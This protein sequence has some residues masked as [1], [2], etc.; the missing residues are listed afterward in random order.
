M[1]VEVG[2]SEV[3]VGS[4]DVEVGSSDVEIG[5]SE[6]DVGSS[7]VEIG[8]VLVE[9]GASEVEV[10]SSC[11]DVGSTEVGVGSSVVELGSS[12]LGKEEVV[13]EELELSDVW[14]LGEGL[15]LVQ[16]ARASEK[17]EKRVTRNLVRFMVILS[18]VYAGKG[19]PYLVRGRAGCLPPQNVLSFKGYEE[20]DYFAYLGFRRFDA[21]LMHDAGQPLLFRFGVLDFFGLDFLFHLDPGVLDFAVYL[22]FD[23]FAPE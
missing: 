9:V 15:V 13:A 2:S 18:C 11:V 22:D 23:F 21:R 1:L 12:V 4:S 10:G 20:T 14:L 5:S 7:E 6:V 3:E 8:S 17:K 16:L 19:T